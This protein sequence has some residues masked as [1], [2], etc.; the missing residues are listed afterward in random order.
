MPH[1]GLTLAPEDGYFGSR[2][3]QS[4]V[5]SHAVDL[6]SKAAELYADLAAFPEALAPAQQALAH[7]AGC[8]SLPGVSLP[9]IMIRA[10]IQM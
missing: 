3:F 4:S 2:A 1:R 6:V 9:H 7:V 10:Q 5:M 8:A